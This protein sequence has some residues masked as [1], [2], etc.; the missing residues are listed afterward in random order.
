MSY[1]KKFLSWQFFPYFLFVIGIFSGYLS[2]SSSP[3]SLFFFSIG[4]VVAE[5]SFLSGIERGVFLFFFFLVLFSVI[6]LFSFILSFF[7]VWIVRLFYSL[8]FWGLGRI[9]GSVLHYSFLGVWWYLPFLVF[10][11]ACSGFF[12]VW[13]RVYKREF[14][15]IKEMFYKLVIT[16]GESSFVAALLTALL[17]QL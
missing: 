3:I 5:L 12:L 15:R 1:L 6:S 13:R 7:S 9:V 16:A 8:L 10:L 11:G 14:Q 4:G 17:W 2:P